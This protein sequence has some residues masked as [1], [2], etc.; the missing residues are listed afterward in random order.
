MLGYVGLCLGYVGLCYSLLF[1]GLKCGRIRSANLA[2]GILW[3]VRVILFFIIFSRGFLFF[4]VF[5][6]VTDYRV[7]KC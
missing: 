2:L 3:P 6:S 1:G 5:V 7:R 4:L